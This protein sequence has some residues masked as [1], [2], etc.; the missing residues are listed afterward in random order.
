MSKKESISIGAIIETLIDMDKTLLASVLKDAG[1]SMQETGDGLS[2][3]EKAKIVIEC[4]IASHEQEIL[5]IKE[6]FGATNIKGFFYSEHRGQWA[7]QYN[8]GLTDDEFDTK[9]GLIEFIKSE[10]QSE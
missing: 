5:E 7:L 9:A 1:I 8:N 2:D 10:S 4:L 6:A 3:E